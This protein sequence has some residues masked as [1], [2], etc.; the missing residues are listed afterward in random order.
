MSLI[1]TIKV[2]YFWRTTEEDPEANV[3]D[4]LAYAISSFLT[5]LR[6]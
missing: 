6:S 5:E 4:K 2:R 1:K 3:Q